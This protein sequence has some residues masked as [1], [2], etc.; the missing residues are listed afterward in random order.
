MLLFHGFSFDRILYFSTSDL[1]QVISRWNFSVFN[2]C[3]LWWVNVCDCLCVAWPL[4]LRGASPEVKGI[5]QLFRHTAS[6]TQPM[7]SKNTQEV[8]GKV[9]RQDHGQRQQADDCHEQDDVALEGQVCDRVDA[10]FASDLLISADVGERERERESFRSL[11]GQ[12]P[13]RVHTTDKICKDLLNCPRSATDDIS[14]C[15]HVM[16]QS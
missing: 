4:S 1:P 13:Q 6:W 8:P 9:D 11:Q 16:M 15:A 2:Q 12:T 10:A 5:P 14:T 7:R 3:V